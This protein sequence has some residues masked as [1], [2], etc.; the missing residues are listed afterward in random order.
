MEPLG[1]N[2]GL[3]IKPNGRPDR[4]YV[5][6]MVTIL[7]FR[8][9][10]GEYIFT[11]RQVIT[12]VSCVMPLAATAAKN[13]QIRDFNSV[14]KLLIELAKL[15]Q[16][17]IAREEPQKHDH[18][19]TVVGIEHQRADLASLIQSELAGRGGDESP[20]EDDHAG[21]DWP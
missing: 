11:E 15:E 8:Q 3:L 5:R 18:S 7:R 1:G 20:S 12:L 10:N 2:G 19:H 17:E 16:T 13:G 21:D 6:D 14:V 4:R 9:P